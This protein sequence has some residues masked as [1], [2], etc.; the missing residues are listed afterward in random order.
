LS[1]IPL[2]LATECSDNRRKMA[3]RLKTI[4]RHLKSGL[5]SSTVEPRDTS[6]GLQGPVAGQWKYTFG[7]KILTAEQRNYF[8]ENGFLV[9]R[10][11]VPKEKLAVYRDRFKE[12]CKG[13]VK[14]PG[15]TVMKDVAIV[16]S[17]FTDGE[18]AIN[19]I[20]DFQHDPV[21]FEYCATPE[22]VRYLEDFIGPNIMAMHTM[23]INKPPDPGTL[24]SRHPMHQD[25]HYFPFRPAERIICAWTAMEKINREN[26]CLVVVPG[27]HRGEL[28][29]HEYPKWQGGVNKMYHGI[30]NYDPSQERVHLLME[31]GDTVFFH[32]LLIHGSGANRSPNFRKAISTHYAASECEY[33]DTTGT[34]QET[35]AE[36]VKKIAQRK[37]GGGDL[38]IDYADIWRFR[39][40][41]VKGEQINL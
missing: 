11:C 27:T 35:I 41:L 20:Q 29:T 38:Q 14:V 18:K 6:L 37:A 16:K 40:R 5:P 36:E 1:E 12:I 10:N 8:E 32:P 31:E 34:S 4:Q 23:L 30:Q 22:V 17:E 24:T 13:N 15:M 19:K 28:L 3:E 26:G 25:L 39:A 21:L 7:D 2:I 9:I 33:I